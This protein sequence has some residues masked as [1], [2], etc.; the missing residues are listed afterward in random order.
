M[1]T[2]RADLTGETIFKDFI[3]DPQNFK[4][5]QNRYIPMSAELMKR[6][7]PLY[8]NAVVDTYGRVEQVPLFA[9]WEEYPKED[10]EG[11]IALKMMRCVPLYRQYDSHEFNKVASQPCMKIEEDFGRKI[12]C[13]TK[14]F[15]AA[16]E[17]G[18][19]LAQEVVTT[20]ADDGFVTQLLEDEELVKETIAMARAL[21][22]NLLPGERYSKKIVEKFGCSQGGYADYLNK[23]HDPTHYEMRDLIQRRDPMVDYVSMMI[24][25]RSKALILGTNSWEAFLIY[26]ELKRLLIEA[27]HKILKVREPPLEEDFIFEEQVSRYYEP[28]RKAGSPRINVVPEEWFQTCFSNYMEQVQPWDVKIL[29]IR[30]E[31]EAYYTWLGYDSSGTLDYETFVVK[32][33]PYGAVVKPV[34]LNTV[35]QRL[36]PY[37]KKVLVKNKDKSTWYMDEERICWSLSPAFLLKPMVLE[38]R[39]LGLCKEGEIIEYMQSRGLEFTPEEFRATCRALE[40]DKEKGLT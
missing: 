18:P 37:Y 7:N 23:F 28:Y 10:P 11:L 32:W 36:I 22:Q 8:I 21:A 39:D 31:K 1:E 5:M 33:Y 20:S 25:Q 2:L 16:C 24:R 17:K 14:I 6:M 3:E 30:K 15:K 40:R 13:E 29:T 12:I 35:E 19:Q 27:A 38:A 9:P 4:L 34:S 26:L